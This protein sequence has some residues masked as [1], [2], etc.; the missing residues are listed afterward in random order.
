M[1]LSQHGEV[2]VSYARS[3]TADDVGVEEKAEAVGLSDHHFVQAEQSDAQESEVDD[4][5]DEKEMHEDWNLHVSQHPER[6][7]Q[8]PRR[9][10]GGRVARE[11]TCS[12]RSDP[13]PGMG[14]F[15]MK[16]K[17]ET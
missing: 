3:E 10:L 5:A 7:P 8:L 13:S 4:P 15:G 12:S 6:H 14:T 11:Q 2:V 1:R 9:E 17:R 16:G